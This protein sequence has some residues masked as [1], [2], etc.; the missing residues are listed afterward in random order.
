MLLAI[1]ALGFLFVIAMMVL[2]INPPEAWIKKAY[3]RKPGER[4]E[5]SRKPEHD[6]R[7]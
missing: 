7:E 5:T 3:H 4:N 6:Q 1:I 2:V